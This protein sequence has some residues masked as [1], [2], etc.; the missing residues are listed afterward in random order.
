M[1]ELGIGALRLAE[2]RLAVFACFFLRKALDIFFC[3]C[4]IDIVHFNLLLK[5]T[6]ASR[7]F[8]LARRW[9]CYRWILLT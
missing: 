9:G 3:I 7:S 6:C 5:W 4:Y 1:R 8:F 2:R